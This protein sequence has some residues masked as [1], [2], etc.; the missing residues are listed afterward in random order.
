MK[1]LTLLF[2]AFAIVACSSGGGSST[3][4]TPAPPPPSG[5]TPISTVQGSGNTSPFEGQ[6]VTVVGVVTGDF[7]DNDADPARNLGGFYLQQEI[8][9][10]DPATSEGIFIFDGNSATRN[11]DVGDRV[12]VSGVVSEFFGETQIA[13]TSVTRTG[14]G[15]VP[16][17]DVNLPSPAV[18]LNADGD[19]VAELEQF[20]GMLVRFPQKLTVT[21]L[22]FLEQFG[23][24]G[25][26]ANGRLLQYTNSN[27]P[28]AAAYAAHKEAIAARQI[29]L[30][31]GLRSSNPANILHLAAGSSAGYSIRTGDSITAA[32]GNLRYA[33]G[34]G[35]SGIE[36]WRI[37]P[38]EAPVFDDDNPR[39]PAPGIAGSTRV[40]SFNVLNFFSA[41][42][43]GQ[44]ICGP[45]G[46]DNCRGADSA[47]EL[48]RQ[49]AKTVTALEMM[50]AQI[51]GLIE[52]ENN[53]AESIVMLVDAL[54]SKIGAND[55]AFVNTGTIND[56]AIKTGFIYN[57]GAVRLAG[58][59]AILD[60]SVDP[61]FA[62]SRNRPA[63]AQAFEIISSGAVFSVVVNHFKSKG[64]SCDNDG[65]PNTSDGQGNCNQTR[66]NAAAALADWVA[67][68]PT[69]SG[70]HDYLVIGDLNAYLMEDPLVAMRNAGLSNLLDS[71]ATPYSFV[72]DGQAGA[73]DH[74]LVS[75]SLV[76]QVA[77]VT[78]W[79][80]NADE[81]QLLDYNLENGRDATLFDA[82]VPYR[83]SDHDP[84]II[85]LDLTN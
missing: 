3:P 73:L 54:N 21:N 83:A 67:T 81:P 75:A 84:V 63:L 55:Y 18:V 23:E 9:D 8:A 15:S 11:V 52:L 43:T 82:N 4:V 59:F 33:K 70:D 40:A 36:T 1:I 79:H 65:D 2:T 10:N 20:E 27:A 22:R 50:D 80:I 35:G 30:D 14:S 78:E 7:Q 51:I 74:A 6:S 62:E 60:S 31:D 25:L 47:E 19:P 16:P 26:S 66:T 44:A 45:Q 13:P 41:V 5:V 42:D 68:D 61:R 57:T 28:D 24:A 69:G 53:A 72:F 34:S 58:A 37:M 71:Q 49:L 17:T 76:N 48:A 46:N 64:S 29:V 12:E 85:G 32:T 39:P 56:D 38:R 77:G